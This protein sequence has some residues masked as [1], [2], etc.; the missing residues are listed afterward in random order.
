MSEEEI[1]KIILNNSPELDSNRPYSSDRVNE[2][3]LFR[4]QQLSSLP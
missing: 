3:L 2:R 1:K 4:T